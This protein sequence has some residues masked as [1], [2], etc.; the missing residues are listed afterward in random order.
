MGGG[1]RP[2]LRHIL[3]GGFT[4]NPIVWNEYPGDDPMDRGDPHNI[5]VQGGPQFIRDTT[6]T[7]Y[8]GALVSPAIGDS[9]GGSR[10]GGGGNLRPPSENYCPVNC[11]SSDTGALYG[12]K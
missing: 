8:K 12:D 2:D 3:Q 6:V 4:G 7:Q 5:L 1:R 9:N 11:D 10:P